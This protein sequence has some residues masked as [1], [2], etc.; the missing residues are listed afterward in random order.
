MAAVVLCVQ[1]RLWRP[2]DTHNQ[3]QTT[4]FSTGP[5]SRGSKK[6]R[7]LS[8]IFGFAST[9]ESMNKHKI[10]FQGATDKVHMAPY[11]AKVEAHLKSI[12]E[13]DFEATFHTTTPPAT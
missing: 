7:G 12:L 2:H 6:K 8:L 5:F 11:I 3:G 4:F 9:G 1:L 13:P 10:W